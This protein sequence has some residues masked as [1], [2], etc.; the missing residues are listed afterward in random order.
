MAKA[1]DIEGGSRSRHGKRKFGDARR[2]IDGGW[3]PELADE[4][5]GGKVYG[6]SGSIEESE[7]RRA[8]APTVHDRD[9]LRQG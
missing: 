9:R 3:W 1:G 5:E 8:L 4:D 7:M 2:G 6:A